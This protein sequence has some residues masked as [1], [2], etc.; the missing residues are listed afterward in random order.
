MS[1]SHSI[2]V[3]PSVN[4][5]TAS[6][7]RAY[8]HLS[9]GSRIFFSC[10]RVNPQSNHPILFGQKRPPGDNGRENYSLTT[11]HTPNLIFRLFTSQI[12]ELF[13]FFASSVATI[14]EVLFT[15]SAPLSPWGATRAAAQRL[16]AMCSE[17][18]VF[19]GT[20]THNCLP[21]RA[22]LHGQKSV[23]TRRATL[24]RFLPAQKSAR[25]DTKVSSAYAFI[26]ARV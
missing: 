22:V 19:G 8:F 10:P 7:S 6:S 3:G 14:R 25:K 26:F 15:F 20:L 23:A 17:S 11:E 21:R 18:R 24:T 13:F 1:S 4:S 2:G 12:A 16:R 9:L 5:P